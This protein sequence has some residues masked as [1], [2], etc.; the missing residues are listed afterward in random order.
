[1]CKLWT[2]EPQ[3]TQGEGNG[4]CMK[5]QTWGSMWSFVGTGE[6]SDAQGHVDKEG[7]GGRSSCSGSCV[8]AVACHESCLPGDNC[9]AVAYDVATKECWRYGILVG[10]YMQTVHSHGNHSS[11]ACYVPDTAAGRDLTAGQPVTTKA[12]SPMPRAK[13]R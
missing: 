4:V 7:A 9:G 12:S 5:K 11:Y 10:P 3:A 13:V 6:C 1:M 8:D 2:R